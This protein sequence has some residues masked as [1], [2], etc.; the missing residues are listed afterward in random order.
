ML[1]I[2]STLDISTF[3]NFVPL[4]PSKLTKMEISTANPPLKLSKG[5]R[6]SLVFLYHPRHWQSLEA[7]ESCGLL[8]HW[9][10]LT[11]LTEGLVWMRV[12]QGHMELSPATESRDI[13]DKFTAKHRCFSQ[14]DN[15]STDQSYQD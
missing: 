4:T 3:S 6:I 8:W 12:E 2:D 14:V 10:S 15:I 1:A 5:Q 13:A 11:H 9:Q 7:L